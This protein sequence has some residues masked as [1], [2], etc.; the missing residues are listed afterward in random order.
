MQSKHE[1]A[2]LNEAAREL[3]EATTKIGD[4]IAARTADL[5]RAQ[6]RSDFNAVRRKVL[7]NVSDHTAAGLDR[8]VEEVESILPRFLLHLDRGV[9]AFATALPV[10]GQISKGTA[11]ERKQL[12]KAV[13]T[14]RGG[15][16][17]AASGVDG[18]KRSLE[19]TPGMTI[20]MNRSRRAAA[21][22][23]QRQITALRRAELELAEVE[24][25]VDDWLVDEE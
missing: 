7:R 23:L 19:N 3:G 17:N 14:L 9:A 22:I 15:L 1:F 16:A 5:E 25:L 11:D 8:Y 12:Q 6:Q 2:E 20:A 13:G 4:F 24:S 21:R 18:F 10:Q